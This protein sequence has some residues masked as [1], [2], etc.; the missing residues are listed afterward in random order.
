[1]NNCESQD[2]ITISVES[3]LGL[4]ELEAEVTVYPNPAT[5]AITIASSFEGG[6][7]VMVYSL[8]GRLIES[9]KTEQAELVIDCS[10]WAA[11]TYRV[12]MQQNQGVIERL[13]IKN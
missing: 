10:D 12:V 11:G 13:I 5:S 4:D 8:E 1:V 2:E 9:V 7:N 6:M 3:C